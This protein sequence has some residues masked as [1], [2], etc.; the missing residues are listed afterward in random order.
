MKLHLLS[1][2]IVW[3]W[4]SHS[5]NTFVQVARTGS[6]PALAPS[7][8]REALRAAQLAAWPQPAQARIAQLD[9]LAALATVQ[10]A[11]PENK[12]AKNSTDV[13]KR[14]FTGHAKFACVS[15]T[16]LRTNVR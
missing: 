13:S 12:I 14:P 10:A 6:L 8:T 15:H 2:C 16:S 3:G 7:G 9:A 1:F 5:E 4:H 11:N